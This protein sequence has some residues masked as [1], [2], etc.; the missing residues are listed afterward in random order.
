MSTVDK[1]LHTLLTDRA[2]HG[3]DP[4]E[5]QELDAL[6]GTRSLD[7]SYEHAA[8]AIELT[9]LPHAPVIPGELEAAVFAAA[10]EY[11]GFAALRPGARTGG[12]RALA[13]ERHATTTARHQVVEV[14][15]EDEDEDLEDEDEGVENEDE[16]ESE[17]LED[18]DEGVENE[19]DVEDEDDED[20]DVEDDPSDD[21][22]LESKEEE[23]EE[24]EDDDDESEDDEEV[25][26][27]VDENEDD[28]EVDESE[29]DDQPSAP[30]PP[31]DRPK[32]QSPPPPP[33]E[34]Q[35]GLSDLG[36]TPTPTSGRD[37]LLTRRAAYFSAVVAVAVLI[38][39]IWMLRNRSQAPDRDEQRAEVEQSDDKIQWTF[40]GNESTVQWSRKRQLGVLELQG[41]EANEPS[42]KQYQLWILDG[43]RGGEAVSA[44]LFDIPA[45][46][47]VFELVVEPALPILGAPKAFV[48]TSEPA[49][50]SVRFDAERAVLQARS[51]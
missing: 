26:E 11:W 37:D 45:G 49:G 6:L 17:D 51:P 41:L 25:D 14:V 10:A 42:Q 19:D 36:L 5:Q 28:E 31:K 48:V 27:E 22:T 33:E 9:L 24:E 12:M 16:D 18:E 50:G 38:L 13:P 20:E 3:L 46:V 2:I 32:R 21:E 40:A 8:A 44:G 43:G 7:P 35:A 34:S 15:E 30:V 1:R 29:D 47:E 23:E 39:A 4:R